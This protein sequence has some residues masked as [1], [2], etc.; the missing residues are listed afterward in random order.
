MLTGKSEAK[1]RFGM[2]MG[3]RGGAPI[4]SEMVEKCSRSRQPFRRELELITTRLGSADDDLPI[5]DSACRSCLQAQLRR[6][7]SSRTRRTIGSKK[8]NGLES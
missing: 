3:D 5:E 1:R 6:R 7:V 8:V 2:L 4:P